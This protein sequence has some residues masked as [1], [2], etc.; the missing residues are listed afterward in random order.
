[1]HA[2]MKDRFITSKILFARA[3][4][5]VGAALGLTGCINRPYE[6]VYGPPPDV[7]PD[8]EVVEDV[9]GPPVENAP[10]S[11]IHRDSVAHEDSSDS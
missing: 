11:V 3:L 8:V 1:M 7:D 4:V 10:D 5:A 2:V 6:T 9:Y